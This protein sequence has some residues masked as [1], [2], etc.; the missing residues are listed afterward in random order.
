MSL[1]AGVL[2]ALDALV[3]LVTLLPLVPAQGWWLRLGEFPRIQIAFIASVILVIQLPLFS[4][5]PIHWLL[6][7]AVFTCIV[8]Q[9]SWVMPYTLIARVEVLPALAPFDEPRC[10]SVLSSNVLMSNRDVD[11]LARMIR[12]RDPDIVLLLETNT[13]WEEQMHWLRDTHPHGMD[14]ALDNRYGMHLYSRLPLHDPCCEFLVQEGVPSMH[15][16]VELRSGH[17]IRLRCLHPA[18]PTP[19]ENA[20]SRERDGELLVVARAI[21]EDHCSVIATGDF[22]DVAWSPTTGVFR[23]VSRLLDPRIGRGQFNTFPAHFPLLRFPL[24][25]VFHSNDFTLV[26]LEVLPRYGSDHLPIWY[27][28]QYEPRLRELQ[29]AEQADR[30]DQEFARER[31]ARVNARPDDVPDPGERSI[32]PKAFVYPVVHAHPAPS[33]DEEQGEQHHQV[34]DRPL[35][36]IV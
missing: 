23:R 14:C 36:A 6:H 10:I 28:L 34:G 30:H 2:L 1:L 35:D 19:T 4:D 17:R 26:G 24:D 31:S 7:A 11:S 33:A 13:W 27:K 8:Y 29:Q 21:A 12:E 15:A 3:V 20:T 22:N 25:H 18:P 5:I 16:E 9:L 32:R